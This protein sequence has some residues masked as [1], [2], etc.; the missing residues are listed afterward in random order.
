MD[1]RENAVLSKISQS[2]NAEQP[3]ISLM[4]DVTL[5]LT[6]TDNSM[7]VARGKGQTYGERR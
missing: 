1:G 5:K 3:V 4:W 6:D 7:V 2:E